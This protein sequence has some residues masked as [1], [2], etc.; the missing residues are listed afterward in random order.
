MN[1][2]LK[3][4]LG[5]GKGYRIKIGYGQPWTKLLQVGGCIDQSTWDKS[6]AMLVDLKTKFLQVF[7]PFEHS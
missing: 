1:E 4:Q 6:V 7:A 3:K 2:T 5:N